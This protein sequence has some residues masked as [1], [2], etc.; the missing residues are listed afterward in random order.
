[1]KLVQKM[2]LRCTAHMMDD[3]GQNEEYCFGEDTSAYTHIATHTQ[4]IVI[5]VLSL[6]NHSVMAYFIP[7]PAILSQHRIVFIKT[8]GKH[9]KLPKW[10]VFLKVTL[11]ST[12][13]V[14]TTNNYQEHQ[15]V[16]KWKVWRW[17]GYTR[18]LDKKCFRLFHGYCP[19]DKQF[20]EVPSYT[21]K[22]QKYN[23]C[24]LHKT[25]LQI[26]TS[27]E[28]TST[29]LHY[30]THLNAT[31]NNKYSSSDYYFCVKSSEEQK[32]KQVKRRKDQGRNL[33]RQ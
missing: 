21:K 16:N 15:L 33:E 6:I 17:K 29:I 4:V 28:N 9:K 31:I 19:Q 5:F 27:Q 3:K 12:V 26:V 13:H 10:W 7:G 11:R 18:S 14:S 30:P 20:L 22:K 24:T 1:M 32:E 25:I 23:P 2:A 8:D